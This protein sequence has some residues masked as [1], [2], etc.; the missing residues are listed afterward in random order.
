M[1][2][3][4]AYRD[5]QLEYAMLDRDDDGVLEYAQRFISSEG[6]QDGL[7]WETAPDEPESPLGPRF[8]EKRTEDS[9][10]GYHYR[11]LTSQGENAPGGAID[12]LDKDN[13]VGGFAAVAWPVEY[14]D[15][16]V[17][18]FML[19]RDGVLYEALLGP[20]GEGAVDS[21]SGFDPD[22]RWKPVLREFT[23]L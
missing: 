23:A 12:Y 18:S 16:G 3:L 10:Y 13:L 21:M 9:Y 17:M 1:Q 22:A 20:D 8:A 14:G 5:A 2:A 4:L 11:I 15:S 19:S 6:K 7:Y